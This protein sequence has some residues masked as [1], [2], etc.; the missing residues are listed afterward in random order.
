MSRFAL[1]AIPLALLLALPARA[2]QQAPPST[3]PAVTT[4]APA[5]APAMTARQVAEM[6]ADVL[7]AR[8]MYQEAISAYQH[9]LVEHPKDAELLN[10]IGVAY[11]QEGLSNQAAHYYKRAI[12]ADPKFA[13]ALNN[14]G[15]VEYEHKHYRKAVR[16][17]QRAVEAQP[18]MAPAYSNMGFAYFADK[19]YPDAMN[20]FGKAL[21]LDR[22]IF[23]HKGGYGSVLQQRSVT[24]PGLFYFFVA[25]SY[26]VAG[27]A[28]HCAHFLKM[29]RDEGYKGFTEAQTDPAFAAVLKDPRVQEVFQADRPMAETPKPSPM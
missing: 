19:Q 16:L 10:K 21:S 4:P 28:E 23:E 17:Y 3:P 9:I 22:T 15:T 24:D 6:H 20:A 1:A 14:L 11:Q 2:Q 13:N 25:K 7:A 29:A 26:A 18:D 27:D 8:K 12:K 5:S